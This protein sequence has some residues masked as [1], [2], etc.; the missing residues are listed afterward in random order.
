MV[1]D[2]ENRHGLPQYLLA[3]VDRDA[4]SHQPG[5]RRP[6]SGFDRLDPQGWRRVM[7]FIESVL[8]GLGALVGGRSPGQGHH[9]TGAGPDLGDD[10]G[11][12][13]RPDDVVA[14]V[15]LAGDAVQALDVDG[16]GCADGRFQFGA[17]GNAAGHGSHLR[18]FCGVTGI[19]VKAPRDSLILF[20]GR[21]SGRRRGRG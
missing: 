8:V 12:G 6:S 2:P 21:V 1:K 11:G 10:A 5:Q 15:V 17:A 20:P 13:R 4:L 16:V 14:A 9:R 3:V 18:V 7:A 19:V